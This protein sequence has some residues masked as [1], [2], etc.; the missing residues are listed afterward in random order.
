MSKAGTRVLV[1]EGDHF[2]REAL[3]LAMTTEGLD[4]CAY[5]SGLAIETILERDNPDVAIMDLASERGPD[6]LALT[7]RVRSWGDIPL[8]IVSSSTRV[9]D[10]LAAFA[11]GADDFLLKPFAM[12]EL[13]ARVLVALRRANLH[14]QSILTV[15][16]VVIDVD[17][18]VATRRGE[19]LDL[20]N[21]EVRLLEMFCRHPNQVL[22]KVQILEKVWGHSFPHVNLVEV[23][24]SNLRRAME[25][26]HPRIIQTVR[27]VGYVLRPDTTSVPIVAPV[28][29]GQTSPD[30]SEPVLDLRIERRR[31]DRRV[32][33]SGGDRRVADADLRFQQIDMAIS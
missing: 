11:A 9:D 8:I 13:R 4:V 22:S 31:G 16:D 21:L 7:R 10:R 20:R 2:T 17:G 33:N 3:V 5:D 6:G 18:H 32:A 29:N 24:V 30:G 19:R 26:D 27:G 1:I 28:A 23:H 12:S 14:R 25:R 15:G